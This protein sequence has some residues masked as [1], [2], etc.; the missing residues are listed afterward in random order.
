MKLTSLPPKSF[1]TKP[2]PNPAPMTE[3]DWEN[4]VQRKLEEEADFLNSIAH[5][6]EKLYG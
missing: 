5:L 3:Q 6:V 4:Y 2:S 1:H